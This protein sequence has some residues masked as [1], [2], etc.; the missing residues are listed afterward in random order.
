[1][2]H[3]TA[4]AI[5]Y[6]ARTR[7]DGPPLEPGTKVVSKGVHRDVSLLRLLAQRLHQDSLKIALQSGRKPGGRCN[8]PAGHLRRNLTSRIA[9]EPVRRLPRQEAIEDRAQ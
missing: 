1:M 4:R 7:R 9:F 2:P 5:P 6:V 3:P 8:R